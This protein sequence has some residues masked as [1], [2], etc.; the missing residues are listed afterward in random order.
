MAE[1]RAC[2]LATVGC[3]EMT[4]NRLAGSGG[5]G[6][7]IAT[8]LYSAALAAVWAAGQEKKSEE[9]ACKPDSV[10]DGHFSGEPVARLL[11]GFIAAIAARTRLPPMMKLDSGQPE[12]GGGPPHAPPIWPCSGRGLPCP[13]C[14]HRGGA[15]L[16]TP[17]HRCPVRRLG[18][19]RLRRVN[20][21]RPYNREHGL[22]VFCGT[23]RRVA[24]PG[25]YPAPCPAESGL[26]SPRSL[27]QEASRRR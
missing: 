9:R 15:L 27:E 16:P 25:R 19:A 18:A 12:A 24:P 13:R 26:S 5:R 7:E 11:V 10:G 21:L 22:C 2:N 23:F 1:K 14:H 8:L 6:G 3:Q 4:T 20:M 17:F